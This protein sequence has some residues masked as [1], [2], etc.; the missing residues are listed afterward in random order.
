MTTGSRI[1]LNLGILFGYPLFAVLIM[2]F[3]HV[4]YD[5][6]LL[7]KCGVEEPA[8]DYIV[9]GRILAFLNLWALIFFVNM[10]NFRDKAYEVKELIRPAIISAVWAAIVFF[11][12]GWVLFIA[13]I[14][15]I[16]LLGL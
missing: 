7:Y 9:P 16:P 4:D 1:L 15:I 2:Y 6:A 12:A 8:R 13:G 3:L 10:D 14:L 5:C 11:L